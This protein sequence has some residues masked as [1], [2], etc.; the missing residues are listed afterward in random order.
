MEKVLGQELLEPYT[1]EGKTEEQTKSEAKKTKQE[2][3]KKCDWPE[4][5]SPPL[6]EI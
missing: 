5:S 4:S 3:E 2:T 6:F 1:A